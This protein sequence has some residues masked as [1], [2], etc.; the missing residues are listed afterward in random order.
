MLDTVW[1]VG[2]DHEG[3]LGWGY[4]ETVRRCERPSSWWYRATSAATAD[5]RSVA[6]A[7]RSSGDLN[8]I[9]VSTVKVGIRVPVATLLAIAPTS[10]TV[11]A[12]TAIRYAAER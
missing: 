9:T 10:D 2:I 7:A 3:S 5:R 12:F 4:D 8:P 1:L 6:K 11:R